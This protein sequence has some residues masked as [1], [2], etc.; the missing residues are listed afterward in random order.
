MNERQTEREL[1]SLR[2]D[3]DDVQRR[4]TYMPT[5]IPTAQLERATVLVKIVSIATDG[6]EYNGT[7][8]GG[9]LSLSSGDLAL[10][11]DLTAGGGVLV[12]NPQENAQPTHWITLNT[13]VECDVKPWKTTAGTPIVVVSGEPIYRIASPVDLAAPEGGGSPG[14][15]PIERSWQRARATSGAQKGDGPFTET[16]ITRYFDGSP[17]GDGIVTRTWFTRTR[18]VDAGGRVYSISDESIA[19]TDTFKDCAPVE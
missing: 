15:D 19:F 1:S 10:P 11:Y 12:L 5:R 9:S 6:G 4:L 18:T 7:V 3:L 2:R 16:Y 13:Y 14:E 8:Y 17:D